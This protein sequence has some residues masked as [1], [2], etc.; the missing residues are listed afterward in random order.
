MLKHE[1]RCEAV[2][3]HSAALT[4]LVYGVKSMKHLQTLLQEPT[5]PRSLQ[6]AKQ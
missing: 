4:R 5:A 1:T 3:R 6:I 2:R